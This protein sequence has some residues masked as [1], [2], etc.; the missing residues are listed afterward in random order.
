MTE[1]DV[2]LTP[3]S[4]GIAPVSSEMTDPAR[5]IRQP[6]Y[7]G[8]FNLLGYPALALPAGFSPEG[9]PYS[10]QVV[11]APFAEGLLLSAGHAYQQVTDWH[12]CVPPIVE[13]EG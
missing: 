4:P 2:L 8:P 10:A 3:T 1:V 9:L 11:G 12:R 5:R 7:T 13:Q 6:S